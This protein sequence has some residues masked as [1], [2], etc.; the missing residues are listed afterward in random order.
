MARLE[1]RQP[2]RP[3]EG[4]AECSGRLVVEAQP[5]A[6]QRAWLPGQLLARRQKRKA[7]AA[8]LWD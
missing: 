4:V 3:E 6:P 2:F 7:A 8:E 1:F 5:A